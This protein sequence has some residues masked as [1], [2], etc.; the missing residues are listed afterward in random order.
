MGAMELQIFVSLLVVLGAAF[1]A[2][3]CDFLKGNNE[4]LREFNIELITRQEERE[5]AA[6]STSQTGRM[7]QKLAARAAE[8]AKPAEAPVKASAP[9]QSSVSEAEEG[10]PAHPRRRRAGRNVGPTLPG[11]VASGMHAPAPVAAIAAMED[12]AKRV[13]EQSAS[14]RKEA[15]PIAPAIQPNWRERQGVG[16]GASAAQAGQPGED[17]AGP[18]VPAVAGLVDHAR[19]GPLQPAETGCEVGVAPADT[20]AEAAPAIQETRSGV[21]AELPIAEMEVLE[22]GPAQQTVESLAIDVAPVEAA[23]GS[24]IETLSHADAVAQEP[25]LHLAGLTELEMPPAFAAAIPSRNLEPVMLEFVEES[26]ADFAGLQRTL[27][28]SEEPAPSEA[29]LRP[30]PGLPKPAETGRLALQPEPRPV[31]A[32][33]GALSNS[34]AKTHHVRAEETLPLA[35]AAEMPVHVSQPTR[36][37]VCPDAAAVVGTGDVE[38]AGIPAAL[39]ALS[40][41]TP[42]LPSA[43]VLPLTVAAADAVLPV[44]ETVLE[45]VPVEVQGVTFRLE[46]GSRMQPPD[47]TVELGEVGTSAEEVAELAPAATQDEVEPVM[48]TTVSQESEAGLEP[49]GPGSDEVVRIRVLDE[50]DLIQPCGLMGQAYE[51]IAP[52]ALTGHVPPLG[53]AQLDA[54]IETYPRMDA[55]RASIESAWEAEALLAAGLTGEKE[56]TACAGAR[57]SAR[58]PESGFLVALQRLMP[59]AAFGI[60]VGQ[61]PGLIADSGSAEGVE[62]SSEP[63]MPESYAPSAPPVDFEIEPV[64]DSGHRFI[65]VDNEPEMNPKVVQ[66]PLPVQA[67]FEQPARVA[68]RIPR[69]IHDRAVFED[70]ATQ[71]AKFDGV[72]FLVG[73]TGFE[74]LVADHG[75]PAVTQAVGEATNYFDSLLNTD[76][77]GCWVE[78]SAF[79]MILPAVSADQARQLSTHTAEGLWD[80]QLRSLG[81]LPLIFHWGSTE[82]SSESLGVAVERARE[83]MLESGRARKQVL[84]ASGRF[85]R[86]AV[87]G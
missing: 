70:L 56:L 24:G 66:M 1:V 71:S 63:V 43:N 41:E 57:K 82:A 80:Y 81:N 47:W 23:G 5:R 7:G 25:A 73:V 21:E 35:G 38:E 33:A 20:P 65:E 27:G 45:A 87:N 60:E 28:A 55:S 8:T 9:A 77:F 30:L 53:A 32:D 68:L 50:G 36:R 34:E 84:T 46:S 48:E 10:I 11:Q 51:P 67:T 78:E 19:S 18:V 26:L 29:G 61:E 74:H 12:W 79:V 22:P 3:I 37:I 6:V 44:R 59:C 15:P 58:V 86:R 40:F 83:Q 54:G 52:A 2:L 62:S 75:K 17:I 39:H 31:F 42:Q 16:T 76:G 4:K 85:R 13:I 64:A 72:V 49:G 14:T 69:G